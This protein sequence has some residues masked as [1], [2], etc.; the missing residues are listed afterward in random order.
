VLNTR[1]SAWTIYTKMPVAMLA[2][3]SGN[4]Y[5]GSSVDGNVY[6]HAGGSDD[7]EPIE[8]LARQGWTYP[9]GGKRALQYTM[10]QPNIDPSASCQAQFQVDV[11][12]IASAITAPVENISAD[13]EGAA[14][15]EEDWDDADWAGESTTDRLWYSI[16]GQGRAVAPVVKTY[17][18]ADSVE[19]SATNIMAKPAGRL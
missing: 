4:L 17:S 7:G 18:T 19:W 5:F 1:N 13:S 15:D 2:D 16:V 8:T 10:M 12:F 6:R 14:W 3:L 9:T 11:D